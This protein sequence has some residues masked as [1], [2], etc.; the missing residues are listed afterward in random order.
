MADKCIGKLTLDIT[1]VEKQVKRVDALL[2][3]VGAGVKVDLSS[4]VASEVKKQLATVEAAIKA[5]V[6][7]I[8]DAADQATRAFNGIGSG[9]TGKGLGTLKSEI[10]DI[11]SE[12]RTMGRTVNSAGQ[13]VEAI[14]SSTTTGYNAL[15]EKVREVTDAHGNLVRKVKDVGTQ[16]KDALKTLVDYY[17]KLAQLN[18]LNMTGKTDT[19]QYAKLNN[20]VER[21]QAEWRSI[22]PSIQAVV[23]STE[24]AKNAAK[25]YADTIATINAGLSDKS[26]EQALKNQVEL[27]EKFYQYSAQANTYAQK[28][29]FENANMYQALAAGIDSYIKAI[30]ALNPVLDAEAQAK[31]RVVQ[32]HLNYE[33]TVNGNVYKEQTANIEAYKNALLDML[34][35]QADFN[36]QV[37]SGRLKEGTA[38]YA[39]AEKHL[40]NLET[41]A[42]QAGKNLDQAGRD[43]AMGMQQVKNAIDNVNTSMGAMSDQTTLRQVTDA[44]NDL[45]NAINQYNLAKKASNEQKMNLWQG[46]IDKQMA[47]ITAIEQ[48]VNTL[49]LEKNVREEILLKIEQAK[50]LQDGFTKGVVGGSTAAG[51]LE[52]QMTGLLTRMFSLMAVIRTINSLIQ[53]TVEYVSA[54]S[55]KMNEIQIITQKT[56][57]EV[58]ELGDTYRNIAEQMNVSSLEM[59]DA[60]IYFTRQGL[61]A[62]QIEERLKNVTMYAKTANVEFKAASEIITAVVNSMGLVSKEAEDGRKATQRVADVFL[63][64]GDKAATSGQEIGEAMQKAAASAGA[65][66][67]SLEWLASYIATVSETTRQEARTIGTAFNTIIAR[68]HQIKQSGYNSDDETKIN[69]IAKA[70]SN[71]NVA[72]MD[73]DGNWRDM[74]TILQEVAAKWDGLDGKTKSYIATTMAGVKQQ[75]VFLA[76]MNDMAKGVEGGSRAFELYEEAINSAGTAS[77]KYSTWTDSVTAAQERLT[78]AQEKFYSLL[79]S[80]VIKTWYD[81]L[82]GYINMINQGAAAWGEWTVIVPVV[83]GLI[84][85]LAI[86]IQGIDFSLTA[87]MTKHP[88]L[89]AIAAGAAAIAGL[90]TVINAVASSIETAEKK[91]ARLEETLDTMNQRTSSAA[92]VQLQTAQMFEKLSEKTHLTNSDFEEY[93]DLLDKISAVSPTAAQA[94]SNLKDNL[95][96]QSEA[97]DIINEELERYINNLNMI[98]ASALLE[99]YSMW[100]PKT[101]GSSAQ[102]FSM[103]MSE[104]DKS[105]FG[106]YE[107]QTKRFAAALEEAFKRSSTLTGDYLYYL[108]KDALGQIT[109]EYQHYLTEDLYY[110]IKDYLKSTNGDW[111]TV[112]M[113]IWNDI[114]DGLNMDMDHVLDQFGTD[115]VNKLYTAFS[116][117]LDNVEQMALKKKLTNLIFGEDGTLDEEEYKDIGNKVIGFVQDVLNNGKIDFSNLEMA[118]ALGD[119]LFGGASSGIF[120]EY[121]DQFSKSFLNGYQEALKAGF[122]DADIAKLFEESGLPT[123]ELDRLGE[124]VADQIKQHIS[125]AMGQEDWLSLLD[126]NEMWDEADLTTLKLVQDYMD[127]GIEIE[128]IDELLANSTSIDDFVAKLKEL[129]KDHGVD[130]QL[131]EDAE[132]VRDYVKGIKAS[133]QEIDKLNKMINTIQ[134]GETVDFEDLLNLAAAHPE[135]MSVINDT[136]SLIEAINRLKEAQ[137][138]SVV[139]DM[140]SLIMGD[141]SYA[142]ASGFGAEAGQ[143]LNDLLDSGYSERAINE[144]V[145]KIIISFL[146]ASEKLSSVS[147]DVIGNWMNEMFSGANMDLLDRKILDFGDHFETMMTETIV[148]STTGMAGDKP[149][150]QWNQDVVVN[151]TPITPD[152]QKLDEETFYQYIDE[153]FAKSADINE[154]FE[155][156][157]VAN[158]GMGLLI[159][160]DVDFASFEEGIANAESLA[161]VL[162][163]LQEAYYGVTDA[164][165]TWLDLQMEQIEKQEEL[166]WAKTNGYIEQINELNEALASGGTEGLQAALDSW[167]SY[168]DAMKK[169]IASTYPNLIKALHDAEKA[170]DKTSGSEEK[171]RKATKSMN[172]ELKKSATYASATHFKDVYDATRKLEA[173]TISVTDAYAAFNKELNKVTKASEDINDVQ[174]KLSKNAEVTA[175]DVSNLASVL[176]M[177]AEEILA[178]FPGAVALF[179]QLT[180]AAG[181]LEAAF[182]ALN[183]AAFI[184]ILGTSDVDFSNLENGLLAIQ[185]EAQS[186]IDMLIATGQWEI[187]TVDL[188]QEG[189]MF[190]PLTGAWETFTSSAQATFLKPSGSNPFKRKTTT[191]TTPT[192]TST[193]KKKTGGGGGKKDKDTDTTSSTTTSTSTTLTKVERML[194]KMEQK[195]AIQDY[196]LSYYQAQK[197]YYGKTGQ[198]QGVIE[199]SKKMKEVIQAE[200]EALTKNIKKIEKQIEA[201]KK[202][203]KGLK[204]SDEEYKTVADDLDKLQKTHQQYTKTLVEHKTEL[205]EIEKEM[206]E[207][208]DQI[209]DMEIDLRETIMQAIQDREAKKKSMLSAEIELENQIFEIIKKRYEKERD[210][211]LTVTDQKI[212]ALKKERDLLSEQLA[213]RKKLAD[214]EDKSTKLAQLEEKYNRIVADPTRA[215]EAQKIRQEI[216]AL[217]KEM[218]WDTAEKEVE[219][220]QASIDQQI[221]SLED[222]K[223]YIEQLYED[224]FEHPTKLIEEMRDVLSMTDEEI[225]DWLIRNDE[226]YATATEARRKQMT[227]SWQDTIDDMRGTVKT[228]WDEVEEIIAQGDDY[229]IEFLKEHS[230][231]YQKA[232]KLQAEKYVDEWKKKLEDLKAAHEEV[233]AEIVA[234]Y[235]TIPS[236]TSPTTSTSPTTTGTSTGGGGSRGTTQTVKYGY[237]FTDNNNN[238]KYDSGKV[239]DTNSSALTAGTTVRNSVVAGYRDRNEYDKIGKIDAVTTYLRGGLAYN[240][241]LA[242]LDGTKQDPERV[243]SPYQTKLFETMVQALEKMSTISIPTMPTFG[244]IQTSTGGSTFTFGDIIVH[245]DNLNT[246]DDYDTMAEKVSDVL[247][248]RIGKTSVVGGLRKNA[249]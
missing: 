26:A 60:A 236:P 154:L 195:L 186:V 78:I 47:L 123:M 211:I 199:Y 31:Q 181:D 38:Q 14:V 210:E 192:T 36:N 189:K 182:N 146:S 161:E 242:W 197:T 234:S 102:D 223:T 116:A 48:T 17:S 18:T 112:G 212:E 158:G 30:Q 155:N 144:Y 226:E 220:Q 133:T 198:L 237:K 187:E 241:G 111:E 230:A 222:Y 124:I 68:L 238:K 218:A 55:D 105:W 157:K 44:Y 150:I 3:S 5:S 50:T 219:A 24:E 117:G 15:G 140:R 95:I 122:T 168:D 7:N 231:E 52:S 45:K 57:A 110:K 109:G 40:K 194:E 213:I 92:N 93:N 206:K 70:L 12:V 79:D 125:D 21:L 143:T 65:F 214:E 118:E 103:M 80:N 71:I 49:G 196:Q 100:N 91:M 61:A 46:E 137:M 115:A 34:K 170:L 9:G 119:S 132:A 249:Y 142:A 41:A 75:N 173:G 201:K 217:R 89:M 139:D 113:L 159:S 35:A 162:H 128:E 69:D 63:A 43:A 81:S 58:A 87:L 246:D 174:T 4:Q 77:K 202:E 207:V 66:G 177:S 209:R 96:T 19:A 156:D 74:E 25:L 229:I 235:D 59:A 83:I 1:D 153:L 221:T 42:I 104:W 145:D 11:T 90:I 134:K 184:R 101:M 188:P 33:A 216:E 127:L 107:D 175:N 183:E 97:A 99:E 185:A 20:E 239:Y 169:S 208:Q 27:Y 225:L 204:T 29:D 171:A 200:D 6:K 141:T 179:D 56:D 245:V 129:G 82:A 166:D 76:L 165:K 23:R 2:K 178:D 32:A 64:I 203:L 148:A 176:G 193:Q 152:G 240:T 121:G 51:E 147:K 72:L 205:Y 247:M 22:D 136:E 53:N 120:E 135:I 167:N 243:L 8:Q 28:G 151:V 62:E 233:I 190:N 88:V 13:T 73:Q 67:V 84:T 39:E 37:A 227:E 126:W 85:A 172:D 114:Y 244:N 248:E 180:G 160:A 108:P 191:S 16:Y 215:K 86:A 106:D 54:Y 94:V 98:K 228:Y 131:K 164:N 224:L 163:L 232:G 149:A 10:V 130:E 138:G